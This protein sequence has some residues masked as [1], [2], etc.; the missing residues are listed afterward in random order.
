MNNALL[1]ARRELR[2]YTSSMLGY[3]V[4]AVGLLLI[5]VLFMVR[6]IGTGPQLSSDV[7]SR[8]FGGSDQLSG[9][10][11]TGVIAVAALVLS[12]RQLAGEREQGTLVLLNTAPIKNSEIIASKFLA[13]M[14][15]LFVMTAATAY[16]PALI[17]VNGK[18]SVGQIL[19]GYLGVLLYA[20]AALA[21]GLFASALAQSQVLALVI[22]LPIYVVLNLLWLAARQTDPPLNE[23][24]AGLG[25]YQ[26]QGQF[27]K[28]VLRLENV[29]YYVGISYFFLLAATKTLEAR[30]W[31]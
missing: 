7:L 15:V 8:F 13:G 14:I 30:R 26:H 18:V 2:A 6:A 23:F 28:G 10:G 24:I 5:G 12:M 16:M 22:G 27:T 3:V 4:V 19:V 17:F 25:L 31:R 29:V 9:F 21:L 1:V 11:A 20:G